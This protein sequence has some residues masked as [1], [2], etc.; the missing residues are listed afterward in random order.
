MEPVEGAGAFLDAV[1]CKWVVGHDFGGSTVAGGLDQGKNDAAVGGG[2][3]SV[4]IDKPT[5][6]IGRKVKPADEETEKYGLFGLRGERRAGKQFGRNGGKSNGFVFRR[7]GNGGNRRRMFPIWA[8]VR[9][10]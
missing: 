8:A 1:T 3:E 9:L 6:L 5:K 4:G 7:R 2:R 10:I